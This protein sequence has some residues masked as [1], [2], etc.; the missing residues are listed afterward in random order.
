MA[1]SIQVSVLCASGRI[2]SFGDNNMSERTTT[3]LQTSGTGLNQT[4]G[5]DL[6]NFLVGETIVAAFATCTAATTVAD[7]VG[8]MYAFVENADGS[9]AVPI[10]GGGNKAGCMPM[11]CKPVRVQVGML[12]KGALAIVDTTA[13]DASLVAYCASGKTSVFTVA[14]VADTKTAIVDVTTGGTI[15]Q[16]L[17][18]QRVVKYYATFTGIYGINDDQGGNNFYYAESSQGQLKGTFFPQVV[19][20]PIK[21]EMVACN[22]PILQNDTL[23]VMWG[24]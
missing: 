21:T 10:E 13:T 8:F 3:T 23:S 7:T 14:A 20:A 17:A 1:N 18:G 11:L 6:G 15:G 2:A 24:S 4:S 5:I 12:L 19:R 9:I 22:I 16:S